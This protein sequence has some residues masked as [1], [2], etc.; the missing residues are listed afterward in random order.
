MDFLGSDPSFALAG[1]T[2]RSTCFLLCLCLTDE[3]GTTIGMF[4]ES[5]TLIHKKHFESSAQYLAVVVDGE[6]TESQTSTTYC[7]L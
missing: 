3:M 6:A 7:V 1:V 5:S 2:L 4:L